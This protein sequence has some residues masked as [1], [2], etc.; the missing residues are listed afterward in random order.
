[1]TGVSAGVVAEVTEGPGPKIALVTPPIKLVM[2]PRMPPPLSELG[3]AV[4]A[5]DDTGES[6]EVVPPPEDGGETPVGDE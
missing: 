5:G 2:G 4:M 6:K 1:M 3:D